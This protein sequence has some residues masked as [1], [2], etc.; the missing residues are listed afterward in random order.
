MSY[1]IQVT[2]RA[3]VSDWGQARVGQQSPTLKL[4]NPLRIHFAE[5]RAGLQMW[6]RPGEAE[7]KAALGTARRPRGG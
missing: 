1:E 7:Q 3:K 5:P 2:I 6:A 4:V